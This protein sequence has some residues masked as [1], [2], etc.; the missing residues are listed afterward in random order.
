MSGPVSFS[1]NA[2]WD[3]V[4]KS[5]RMTAHRGGHLRAFVGSRKVSNSVRIAG[6]IRFNDRV[7]KGFKA[8]LLKAQLN[9]RGWW[10]VQDLN[11]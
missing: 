9:L 4:G 2:H 7:P 5:G 8:E 3:R 10:A 11:L 1:G 6:V